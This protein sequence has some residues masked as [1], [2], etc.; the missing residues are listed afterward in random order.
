MPFTGQQLSQVGVAHLTG[1]QNIPGS[2]RTEAIRDEVSQGFY[3]GN[4][5]KLLVS[6]ESSGSILI[7]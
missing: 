4:N 1:E 2:Q 6:E 7:R 3:Y 5:K